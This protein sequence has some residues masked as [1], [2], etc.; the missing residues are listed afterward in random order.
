M[1][2]KLPGRD[3]TTMTEDTAADICPESVVTLRNF[4]KLG[5][6]GLAVTDYQVVRVW[7][8]SITQDLRDRGLSNTTPFFAA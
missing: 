4:A 5:C 3:D 2:T 7:W 1:P 8:T 6:I